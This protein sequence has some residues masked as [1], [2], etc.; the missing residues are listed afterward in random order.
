MRLLNH[1]FEVFEKRSITLEILESE[2]QFSRQNFQNTFKETIDRLN[3]LAGSNNNAQLLVGNEVTLLTDKDLQQFTQAL[4]AL[5]RACRAAKITDFAT[6]PEGWGYPMLSKVKRYLPKTKMEAFS[7]VYWYQFGE[8]D[9]HQ[10]WLVD[11]EKLLFA[12]LEEAWERNLWLCPTFDPNRVSAIVQ[13]L[14]DV[15]KTT[16][17]G[18]WRVFENDIVE[19]GKVVSKAVGVLHKKLT[20]DAY[21]VPLKSSIKSS[22]K[23][24]EA[25]IEEEKEPKE[26]IRNIPKTSFKD[27]GGIDPLLGRIREVIELPLKKPELFEHLHI[28]PHRGILLYGPPGCGKT[29]VAKAIAHE[30]EAHFISIKGPEVLNKY[31]GQSEENLR[32][33]FEEAREMQPSIIFFDEID[34]IAQRRSASDNLR[35]DARIVN[36]LLSLMDGV[37][38]YGHVCVM[39]AT[40]RI[41]LIDEALLRPGRFDYKME[42]PLPNEAGCKAIFDIQTKGMPFNTALNFDSIYKR[43]NGFSGAEIAYTARE[44]AYNCL[45]RNVDMQNGFNVKQLENL[46]YSKFIIEE[47]DLD[48]AF[49]LIEKS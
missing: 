43:L 20:E 36:Q 15:L 4:E 48:Q 1:I 10:N 31:Y 44:S 46:D 42:I 11:K 32:N 12:L 13:R 29:M 19:E 33:L 24:N 6:T 49:D 16:D 22:H 47:A 26:A 28:K 7:G 5:E 2:E 39:A 18:N 30:I 14:P 8:F 34:A 23:E 3:A 35:M 25:G 17:R 21:Q 41:E 27:V 37:E 45:R 38:A 40:N 9:E